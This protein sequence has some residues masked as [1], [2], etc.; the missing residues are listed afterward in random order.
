MVTSSLLMDSRLRG[1]RL[2]GESLGLIGAVDV[3][4]GGPDGAEIVD[5]T[6]GSA[7]CAAEGG[8]E[9]KEPDAI[10]VAAHA[11]LSLGYAMLVK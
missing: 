8:P 4:E 7:R 5:D 1:L 10:Q 2:E 6:E 3:V 9:I 11:L